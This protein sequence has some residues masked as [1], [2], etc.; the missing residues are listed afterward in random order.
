M[1]VLSRKIGESLLIDDGRIEV[2]V[3]AIRGDRIR[4]G[5]V[6]PKECRVVR[7]ELDRGV[8][9]CGGSSESDGVAA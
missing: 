4:L 3:V 2:K 9:S 6:A 8:E 1:L 7:S 5:I